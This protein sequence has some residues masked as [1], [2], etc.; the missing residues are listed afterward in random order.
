LKRHQGPKEILEIIEHKR[1]EW[2]DR[3]GP[4]SKDKAFVWALGCEMLHI[5]AEFTGSLLPLWDA[6]R[7]SSDKEAKR[8]IQAAREFISTDTFEIKARPGVVA[9]RA[10]AAAYA[11]LVPN[12]PIP[13]SPSVQ[14]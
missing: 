12:Q 14:E 11:V 3:S 7:P 1:E 9:L 4:K 10:Y 6:Q 2:L 8:A 13:F 5:S